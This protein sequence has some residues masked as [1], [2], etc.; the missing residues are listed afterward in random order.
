MRLNN[1]L[2]RHTSC[3]LQ[4]VYVLR[5]QHVQQPLLRK[6]RYKRMRHR[7]FIFSGVKL[8]GEHVE[9]RRVLAE[10]GDVEDGLWVRQVQPRQV[11]VQPRVR[12]AEVGNPGA[13]R[14]A[15]AGKDDHSFDLVGL[16]VLGDGA[17]GS[18]LQCPGGHTLVEEL[19]GRF[20]AHF[21]PRAGLFGA[22]RTAMLSNFEVAAG[23]FNF[24]IKDKKQEVRLE[25]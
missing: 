7:R 15:S 22:M 16:E 3:P 2:R 13:G 24:N 5:E 14:D 23:K 8:L 10:E 6:Q 4:T 11:R 1:L 21:A 18:V 9:G 19:V 20:L 25:Y 12:G 17:N